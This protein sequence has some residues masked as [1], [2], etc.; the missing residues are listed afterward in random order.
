MRRGP[1]ARTQR[2]VRTSDGRRD[3]SDAREASKG[4]KVTKPK[5]KMPVS[6][7][8]AGERFFLSDHEKSAPLRVAAKRGCCGVTNPV[9]RRATASRARRARSLRAFDHSG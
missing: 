6:P 3:Y 1:I 4:A 5:K 2:S 7:R 9:V 8:P